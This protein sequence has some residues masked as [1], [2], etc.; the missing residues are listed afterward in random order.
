MLTKPTA[1]EVVIQTAQVEIQVL[2]VA[3]KPVT[4]AMFRQIPYRSCID[5]E[6][7]AMCCGAGAGE[8]QVDVWYPYRRRKLWG[9]VNYFWDGDHGTDTTYS[10]D[11]HFIA[12]YDHGHRLHILWQNLGYEDE[13]I[14][15]R[16]IVCERLP[17]WFVKEHGQGQQAHIMWRRC[18]EKFLELQQLFIGI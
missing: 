13:G 7:L 5:W 18:W 1:Q 8:E 10:R 14:L 15:Y 11:G 6:D 4:L 2:T 12:W 9:H 16:S 17:E 3:K